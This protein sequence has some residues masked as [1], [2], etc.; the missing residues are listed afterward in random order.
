ML[1]DAFEAPPSAGSRARIPTYR[2]AWQ[3]VDTVGGADVERTRQEIERLKAMG[4]L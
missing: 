3:P 4:Y 2:D 1:D